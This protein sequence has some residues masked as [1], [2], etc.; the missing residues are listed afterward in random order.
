MGGAELN[1]G[2][3]TLMSITGRGGGA[4]GG[5]VLALTGD[6]EPDL[7]PLGVLGDLGGVEVGV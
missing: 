3:G 2:G 5:G 1:I 6:L 4:S 7:E